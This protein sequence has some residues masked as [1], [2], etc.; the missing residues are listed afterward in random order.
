MT[1]PRLATVA[2][3]ALLAAGCAA[4]D[5]NN[6]LS[7]RGVSH[8]EFPDM[9]IAAPASL[10]TGAA[11]RM[12]AIEFVWSTVNDRYYDPQMNGADWKAARARWQPRALAAS[13]E[14]EFWDMLDRMTGELR[15]AHT[16]VESPR[17]AAQIERF[18]SISPGFAFRPIEGKLV[19]TS[20][21]AESDAYWAGV[22]PGMTLEE[23]A[24][25]P[26]QAAYAKAL[27]E[28]RLSSTETARH[29]SAA[30]RLLQGEA[31]SAIILTFRRGDGTPFTVSV[32][33]KRSTSP[34]RVTHRLLPSGYGYIRLTSWQQS[35][36]GRMI[37]A[38]EALKATPGLVI[39]LRGNPGGSALMV[40]NVA[41]QFF[42]GKLEFG[43][44]LTRTGKPITLAFDLIELVKVKQ[45]LDGTGLYLKP[46][47]VLVDG[48]SASGSELFAGLLQSQGRA[49]VVGQT[50]CGCLLAYMGYADI[51][52]GG[53]L[54]YSEVGFVFPNG[55]RIEGAGVTPDLPV[56]VTIA[57][58]LV[59]RDRTLEEAQARLRTAEPGKTVAGG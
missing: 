32:A 28:A 43:K 23:V 24:G 44:S 51:P 57:D 58:L 10:G 33:R 42:K 11:G 52:G 34:P 27:T 41:A 15:D 36:Q 9:P 21:S 20:V 35:L 26:A 38:V 3:A 4:F 48:G 53:K 6:V 45:E 49:A 50:S 22:R 54:A 55:K 19:V 46:V 56:A 47:V 29:R 30:R 16:R 13:D 31:D 18:E 37:E 7:R 59:N 14:E 12:A 25:E 39:D 17:R 1:I 40:R 5:P 2:L 8:A